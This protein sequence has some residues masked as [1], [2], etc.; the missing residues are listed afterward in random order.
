MSS[1]CLEICWPYDRL[2][3]SSV[4]PVVDSEKAGDFAALDECS[5]GVICTCARRKSKTIDTDIR[6]MSETFVMLHRFD[7]KTDSTHSWA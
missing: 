3:G 2:P 7:A 1:V 6:R 4:R 5:P